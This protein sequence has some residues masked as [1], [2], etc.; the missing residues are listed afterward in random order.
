MATRTMQ[1]QARVVVPQEAKDRWEG[2]KGRLE[3]LRDF[4]ATIKQALHYATGKAI[5]DGALYWSQD[6]HRY[7]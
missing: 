1:Q 7:A 3:D 6:F 5:E 4:F 2:L